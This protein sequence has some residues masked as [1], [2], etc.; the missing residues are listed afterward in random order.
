[1]ILKKLDKEIVR[2]I[3]YISAWIVIFSALMQSVFLIIG[4]WDYTVLLGNLLSASVGILNFYLLALTVTKAVSSEDDKYR[5]NLMKLSQG[6][7]FLMLLGVAILG[8][9]LPCFHLIATLIPI[10]FPR[11]AILIRPLIIKTKDGGNYIDYREVKDDEE[12]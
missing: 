7:R 11:L 12:S 2:E 10:L 5:K 9:T 4:K 8:A 3:K 1:M 6:L